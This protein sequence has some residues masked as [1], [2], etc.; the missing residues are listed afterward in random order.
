MDVVKTHPTNRYSKQYERLSPFDFICAGQSDD[1]QAALG[2]ENS[3]C[4]A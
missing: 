4:S 2:V 3:Y 1:N